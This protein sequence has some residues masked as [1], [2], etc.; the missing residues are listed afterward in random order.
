MFIDSF[1][2]PSTFWVSPVF[3][4]ERSTVHSVLAFRKLMNEGWWAVYKHR[5]A[6]EV[7]PGDEVL[8]GGAERGG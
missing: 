1:I 2:H 8:E 6:M 3:Q 5:G 7:C 4:G